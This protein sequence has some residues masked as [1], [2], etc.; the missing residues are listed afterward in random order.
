MC[1][2]TSMNQ[3]CPFLVQSHISDFQDYVYFSVTSIALKDA[4]IRGGNVINPFAREIGT[5]QKF[6]S[7]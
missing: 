1:I 2:E 4:N 3:N 6:V 7:L 5:S